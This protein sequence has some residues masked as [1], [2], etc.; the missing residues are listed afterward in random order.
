MF[1]LVIWAPARCT[2]WENHH[3]RRAFPNPTGV[4]LRVDIPPAFPTFTTA[5]PMGTPCLTSLLSRLG[6]YNKWQPLNFASDYFCMPSLAPTLTT[7]APSRDLPRKVINGDRRYWQFFLSKRYDV[8]I[9]ANSFYITTYRPHQ[10]K[11]PSSAP[12]NARPRARRVIKLLARDTPT[13]SIAV[14]VC[15]YSALRCSVTKSVINYYLLLFT[16]PLQYN[17]SQ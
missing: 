7:L 2:G 16:I 13:N 4:S 12:V 3:R 10:R 6:P 15:T 14:C 11:G 5:S 17:P 9:G 8:Q 1:A